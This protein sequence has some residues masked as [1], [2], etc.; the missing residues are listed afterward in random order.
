M[1]AKQVIE[2]QIKFAD[3]QIANAKARFSDCDDRLRRESFD[4][5]KYI[6]ALSGSSLGCY[7]SNIAGMAVDM[8]RAASDLQSAQDL[9]H[10]M[11]NLLDTLN[12]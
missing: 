2:Q 4:A 1:N 8:A 10:Q 3:E 11:Q 7:A 9:K 5:C 6:N 12:G